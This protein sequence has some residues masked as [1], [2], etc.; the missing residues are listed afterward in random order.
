M[1]NTQSIVPDE[2]RHNFYHAIH[3]A[4]PP[5]PL[6]H[7]AGARRRIDYVNRVQH[8]EPAG[9]PPQPPGARQGHLEGENREIHAA[10]EERRTRRFEPM[11]PRTM[12]ITS[13]SFAEIEMLIRAVERPPPPTAR[14]PG[15]RALPPLCRSSWRMTSST[16]TAKRRSCSPCCT[17]AFT[18]DELRKPSKIAS[19]RPC[20]RRRWRP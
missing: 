20:R 15:R 7:A 12:R 13:A 19:S 18:D 3:K 6:P 11:R 8:R 14:L 4:S 10:L 16:W 5:W 9:R 1:T 17:T 2:T